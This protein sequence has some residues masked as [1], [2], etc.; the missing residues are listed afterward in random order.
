MSFGFGVSDFLTLG[1]FCW[2][3]WKRCKDASEDFKNL[4]SEVASFHIVLKE[5]EELLSKQ[6]PSLEQEARLEVLKKGSENVLEDLDKLL[7]K[8][9]S[10]ATTSQRTW[11]RM[12][13]GNQDITALRSRLISQT[14]LLDA[15]NNV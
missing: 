6:T 14:T 1:Q 12:G 8:Y 13:F 15:F 11:D 2:T 7:V 9:E 4:S 10:L 5:T 3:I